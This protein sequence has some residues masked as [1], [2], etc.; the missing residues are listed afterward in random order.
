MGQIYAIIFTDDLVKVGRGK[1]FSDRLA[2][3]AASAKLRGASVKE[4]YCIDVL[5]DDSKAEQ[6]LIRF[7]QSIS[8]K[9]ISNEWFKGVSPCLDDSGI[10]GAMERI[11]SKY[12]DAKVYEEIKLK[13]D[14]LMANSVKSYN[15][16]I[17]RCRAKNSNDKNWSFALDA[18]GV[19]ESLYGGWGYSGSAFDK[20][21]GAELSIFKLKCA[22]YI[23]NRPGKVDQVFT[24]VFYDEHEAFVTIMTED[25]NFAASNQREEYDGL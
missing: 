13:R 12:T 10:K 16:A 4:G 15:E 6:E 17:I 9:K 3:H 20:I 11:R 19:I 23:C 21:N 5:Y 7:V 18:A 25:I 24:D 1:S 22:L 14:A 2:V 8:S